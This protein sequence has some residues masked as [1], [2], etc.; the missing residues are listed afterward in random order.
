MLKSIIRTQWLLFA[1]LLSA[2]QPLPAQEKLS[3]EE[4]AHK[5]LESN[6][7][8]AIDAPGQLAARAEHK[9]ARAGY[10]PRI[11]FEQ[12]Y[13]AGNNPVFVFS[14]LLTQQNFTE[15]NLDLPSLNAPSPE[16]NWQTRAT[17]QQTLY[18]FGRTGTRRKLAET[19]I[20]KVDQMYEQ[21]R[22]Q[23]LL[24]LIDSY[25]SVTLA[26]ESLETARL[27]LQSAEAIES[28]AKARVEEGLAVEADLL[29]SRVHLS[30]TKQR[31]IEASGMLETAEA[32]LNRTM[33]RPMSE[34]VGETEALLPFEAD[35]PS[36]EE[37]LEAMK[38]KR[39]DYLA[40]KT[41]LAEADLA[42]STR[43]KEFLPVLAGF[44]SVEMN[45]PSLDTFGGG[46]W[47]AGITLSWN[48]L[49]GG[50]KF[51]QLDAARQRLEQKRRQVQ[52]VESGMAL[53]IRSAVVQYR[54]A[55]QQASAARAAEAQAEESL[56]I[57]ENR[58][59]AGL[60]TM[61][62]LLTAE[63]ARSGA[64]TNLSQ[65]V[66][67]QRLSLAQLEYVTGTLST[68]SRSVQLQ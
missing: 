2:Q 57:L 44:G 38:Q 26:R 18:D 50:G 61:T 24:A 39:P 3:L 12:S 19:G 67:R 40:L 36:E 55:R 29:S 45:N 5:A 68:S 25:F 14:T 56:R 53:E 35:L 22:Q 21:H 34:A 66:F 30:S 15:A 27:A 9:A 7:D 20:E 48:L 58:Y 16:S 60:A 46:N 47:T 63:T 51:S 23:V 64:R 17:L 42:V 32:R 4:A 41:E 37:L 28:Q 1:L 31:E 59:E 65:A 6:P 8:L 49:S 10:L 13:L 43:K 33:G 62:D 52:A 11:D 54:T